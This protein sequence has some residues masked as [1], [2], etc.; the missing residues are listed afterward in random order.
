MRV[1]ATV[2]DYQPSMWS[3]QREIQ[4]TP[5]IELVIAQVALN[6]KTDESNSGNEQA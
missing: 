1:R 4:G 2:I 3:A 6:G 5:V